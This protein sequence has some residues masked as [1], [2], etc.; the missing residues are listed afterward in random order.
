MCIPSVVLVVMAILGASTLADQLNERIDEALELAQSDR[1][2]LAIT[3]LQRIVEEHPDHSRA[4]L[5]LAVLLVRG[6]RTKDSLA[7]IAPMPDAAIPNFVIDELLPAA[8]DARRF[9]EA[10][11]LAELKRIRQPD[12]LAAQEWLVLILAD[13][14]SGTRAMKEAAQ[15][16]TR[17]PDHARA[18][19]AAGYAFERSSAF[20]QALASY[21]EVI[22]REPE[23]PE[24][25]RRCIL[26][27]QKLGAASRAIELMLKHP[28]VLTKA[29]QASLRA[30][31]AA[32]HISWASSEPTQA[33]IHR[34]AE[35]A[36]AEATTLLASLEQEGTGTAQT[37]SRLRFDRLVAWHAL[38][39]MP[40]IIAEYKALIAEGIQLPTYA[41]IC[42]A[43]AYLQQRDPKQALS[44]YRA[45]LQAAPGNRDARIGEFF[46]LVES[47]QLR[48]ALQRM[49]EWEE[50]APTWKWLKGSPLPVPNDQKLTA[51]SLRI[52]ATY[53]LDQLDEA[54]ALLE[55][56]VAAAP[57]HSGLRGTL[58][59][60]YWA[61]GW[62]TRALDQL[63]L[64]LGL[65]PTSPAA[66]R[67]RASL[68][69]S[70][71]RFEEATEAR[72]QLASTLADTTVLEK[73]DQ[74][75]ANYRAWTFDLETG[76]E[77]SDGQAFASESHYA[78]ARV[79]SPSLLEDYRVF[80]EFRYEH[81]EF[82]EG[83][84]YLRRYLLGADRRG[85]ELDGEL[86]FSYTEAT[87][88]Q[89]GVGLRLLWH[90]GDHW[91]WGGSAE[92]YSRGTPLRA[93]KNGIDAT[94][95]DTDVSYRYHERAA[96]RGRCRYL[97]FSDGNH[98]LEGHTGI[99]WRPYSFHRV[100][101]DTDL[102]LY[103]SF[104]SLEDA[105]YFNPAEHISLPLTLTPHFMLFRKYDRAFWND[106]AMELGPVYQQGYPVSVNWSVEYRHR[107]I[108]GPRWGL[109]YG[110][111]YAS[112]V[113]DGVREQALI[114]SLRL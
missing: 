94:H 86:L 6:G 90:P 53:F 87:V 49:E 105:P 36:A 102:S 15:L 9:E 3:Q 114:A 54:Q 46:A 28:D 62:P 99:F 59:D 77:E 74:Q 48:A 91:R 31:E 106:L 19:L 73:L 45:C 95:V 20:T 101:L 32:T 47:E 5:D 93:I 12:T 40:P 58:A 61:R 108:M 88:E 14:G 85:S 37:Q 79:Y 57:N 81:A 42:V 82:A 52:L 98:R 110:I 24:A 69:F 64:A 60:I 71:R 23:H 96:W 112:R 104:N 70:E 100:V 17:W 78:G 111:G 107:W 29:E 30:S 66:L 50:Q 27:M 18:W 80:G 113:Y 38:G 13:H 67:A 41:R 109:N 10:L 55:P 7:L 8:R 25:L 56:L 22:A 34:A 39:R 43:D 35:N 33:R 26:T 89:P 92:S 44:L 16:V 103:A 97:N 4:R 2:E 84:E 11:R 51:A 75:W 21:Q 68:L 63:D 72:A 65:D 83:P 76:H 1:L